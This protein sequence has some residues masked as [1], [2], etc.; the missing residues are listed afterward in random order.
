M[1]RLGIGDYAEIT[2]IPF[3]NWLLIGIAVAGWTR[4]REIRMANDLQTAEL[5]KGR[6]VAVVGTGLVGAGWA[7]S[8][9]RAGAHVR[10]YD[11]E[12]GA[13]E[14]A[15]LWIGFQ[16]NDMAD[17]GLVEAPAAISER[18]SLSPT[19]EHALDGAAYVQES[20]FE[21]LALKR[22]LYA[23]I[24]TLLDQAAIVGSSTSGIPA[25]AFATDL[26]IA[27]RVLIVH[28]VNPPHLVPVV[29]LVPSPSTA[30]A[31]T[32]W[33]AQLMDALGMS[34]VHVRKE[35][36]GFVL[37]RLQGALLREAWALVEEGVASCAEVDATVRDG[38][39]WRW[40]FMGPFE[41]IDLNAAGGVADYARRLGPLYLSIDRSRE[42]SNSW[43]P[44]L[45]AEVERQCRAAMPLEQLA[46]RRAWRDRQL[47]QIAARRAGRDRSRTNTTL[48][49]HP[50]GQYE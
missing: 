50:E 18:I 4:P 22:E 46:E 27:S 30:P 14:H 49:I 44:E 48:P 9:A 5:L 23:R 21:D 31:V 7:I 16:L 2:T 15:R 34:I 1:S 36:E 37:N 8:F 41:T 20:I 25:S 13:A 47:M 33:A 10:L 12:P 3:A 43:S 35:I 38:L 39:G 40:S 6:A 45:I 29:E 28:P 19:L 32:K 17:L 26:D 11:A 42:H 24:D